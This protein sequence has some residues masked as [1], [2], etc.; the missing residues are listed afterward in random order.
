M[1]ERTKRILACLFDYVFTCVYLVTC[2]TKTLIV[3]NGDS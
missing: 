1:L 3:Q 2:G